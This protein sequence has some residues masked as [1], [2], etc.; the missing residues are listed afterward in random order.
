MSKQATVPLPED[1]MNLQMS[2]Q[3]AAA[4]MA[5]QN[6]TAM[7]M[8]NPV[9]GLDK[10]E[11]TGPAGSSPAEQ[12][13]PD[14]QEGKQSHQVAPIK[15]GMACLHVL[16]VHAAG[17]GALQHSSMHTTGRSGSLETSNCTQH[18]SLSAQRHV[19][20]NGALWIW[21]SAVCICSSSL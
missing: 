18:G 10:Q 8:M 9:L 14:D 11:S 15:S 6:E 12:G 2:V 3:E 5:L 19:S 21:H 17:A 16:D 13:L 4:N 7:K 20:L 1:T